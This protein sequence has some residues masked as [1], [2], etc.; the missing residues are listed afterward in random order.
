MP[1]G[2]KLAFPFVY[3]W[4]RKTHSLPKLHPVLVLVWNAVCHAIAFVLLNAYVNM[5]GNTSIQ[6]LYCSVTV[7]VFLSLVHECG[8]NFLIFCVL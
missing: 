4:S 1:Q 8:F 2:H 3:Y 6:F 7:T 5:V